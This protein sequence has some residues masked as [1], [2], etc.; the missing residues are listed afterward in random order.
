MAIQK[1]LF[2]DTNIWLDFYRHRNEAGLKLLEH[3]E[4]VSDRI[5]V[6]YQLEMEVKKNRQKAIAEG[7]RELKSPQ[8]ISRPGLFSDAKAVKALEK[9]IR[10]AD[11]KVKLLRTRLI[12]ALANPTTHDPVYQACQRIFHRRSDLVLTRDNPARRII[13]RQAFRRFILGCPP[14]KD[15]D[16]SMGDAVNWEWMIECAIRRTAE[17]VIV[18]RDAD[19]GLNIENQTFLNDHLRHEFSERV[20]K[21]RRVR[22]YTLLSEALEH[23]QVPVSAQEKKGEQQLL[24]ARA[25]HSEALQQTA[26]F[27]A[28]ADVSALAAL[29]LG[30]K[31]LQNAARQVVGQIRDMTPEQLEKILESEAPNDREALLKAIRQLEQVVDVVSHSGEAAPPGIT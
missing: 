1:L 12:K 13:K 16:T 21:Q 3:L 25:L 15:G 8:R 19:Y 14:R 5:V 10:S 17:L 20:S 27:V 6:T 31:D 9:S 26:S 4:K 23:F 11:Q 2:V 30:N 22:L 7:L 18:S 29:F 24:A 28:S